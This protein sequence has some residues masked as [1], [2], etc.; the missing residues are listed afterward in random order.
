M[1]YK[2]IIDTHLQEWATSTD[3]MPILLRGALQ[4]GKST[5]VRHLAEQFEHYVEVNFEFKPDF[6]GLFKKDLDVKRIIEE[7]EVIANTPIEAGKTLLFLDE[8]K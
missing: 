2:R 7:I 1:Y 3:R 5:A 4:I 8:V 6:I